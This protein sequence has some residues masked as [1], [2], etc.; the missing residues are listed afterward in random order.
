MPEKPHPDA[1]KAAEAVMGLLAPENHRLS[2]MTRRIRAI[3]AR[4]C[5]LV[6]IDKLLHLLITASEDMKYGKLPA[7]REAFAMA[8]ELL[9]E[10]DR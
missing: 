4:E 10:D 6:E 9:P 1:V 3:I 8:R 5:R 2:P 7:L